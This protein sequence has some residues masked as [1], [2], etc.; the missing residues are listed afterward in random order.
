[1]AKHLT[2]Q[3]IH[4]LSMSKDEV[5]CAKVVTLRAVTHAIR[6]HSTVVKTE[7]WRKNH[8]ARKM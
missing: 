4:A 2:L 8:L 5:F 1:M 7:P 3:G 6:L